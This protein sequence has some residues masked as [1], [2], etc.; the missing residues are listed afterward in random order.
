MFRK[1]MGQLREGAEGYLDGAK[2]PMRYAAETQRLAGFFL[3]QL[4]GHHQI[5]DQQYFPMLAA[6]DAKLVEGFDL[7]DSD[8]LALDGHIYSLAERTNAMLHVA[9]Q[10]GMRDRAGEL[11][12]ALSQF[13]V[14]LNRH[15]EDEEDLVVPVILHYGAPL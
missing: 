15:L 3:N 6:H 11:H 9:G 14:F 7:L 12:T 10:A 5:E 8:H 13:H 2:D 1:V 4:H